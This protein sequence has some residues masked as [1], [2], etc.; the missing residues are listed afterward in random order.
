MIVRPP[1]PYENGPPLLRREM[2][3]VAMGPK[4]LTSGPTPIQP[5][6]LFE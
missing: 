5:R 1:I 6:G 3:G 2:H 4:D